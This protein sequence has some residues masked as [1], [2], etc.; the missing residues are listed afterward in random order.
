MRRISIP[1]VSFIVVLSLTA[2]TAYADLS[3]GLL[4]LH[5]FEDLVD[6]SRNGHDAL[7]GGDAFIEDGLLWLDGNEEYAD[8]GTLAGFGAVNPLVDALSDFT[9]A[10]AYASANTGGNEG[11]SM[12]VSIGPASAGASADLSLAT[13]NDGQGVDLWF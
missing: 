8:I 3:D 5:D 13:N 10:V 6:G 2:N 1:L 7:L 11:G 12:L 4:V 9:I